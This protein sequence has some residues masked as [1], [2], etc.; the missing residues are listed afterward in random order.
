[1]TFRV[2]QKVVCIT[3]PRKNGNW[4]GLH[5]SV[6]GRI[7]TV[8]ETYTSPY[9]GKL[10]L[11]FEEHINPICPCWDIECGYTAER[12]RPIVERKTDIS[13]FTAMLRPCKVKA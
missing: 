13:I 12:F 2:G 5:P 10:S 7:Y 4:S 9:N 1:M 3:A 6:K 8:R 11:R